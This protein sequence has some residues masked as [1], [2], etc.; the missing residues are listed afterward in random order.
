MLKHNLLLIFRGFK[1][2]KSSFVINLIGLSTG[3][4]CALLI[5]FWVNDELSVDRFFENGKQLFQVMQN[6]QGANG[7]ETID[8]TPGHLAKALSDEIPEVEY[9]VA[10]VPTSFN[11][12]KGIVS[13]SDKQIKSVGQYVSED[14]FNVFSYK[15]LYGNKN[16]MLSAQN[17][18]VISRELALKLYGSPGNAVGK[19]V[20]WKAQETDGKYTVSGVFDL[21]DERATNQFDVLLNYKLFEGANPWEG[22]GSSSPHTYVLLKKG[23]SSG[24]F[25][26]KIRDF[27]KS[28]DKN[29]NATLVAQRYSDRYL[30][31]RFENG[32]P[33]GGRI[34][35]VRL[36]S[37]IAIFI[38][39]I[40]CINFM[41]LSTARALGK[42][43]EVGIKKAIGAGR[44]NLIIQRLSESTVMA[45]AALALALFFVYL[46]KTPFNNLT[47]KHLGFS[48]D[49]QLV[50]I[51]LGITL[52]T[53][54]FAGSYPAFYLSRFAP[55]DV[56]KGKPDSPSGGIWARKGLV[57]FQF[58]ASVI[59]I[60]SV[61]VVFEQ[62]AF[63]QSKNLG[64]NRDHVVYF[65]VAKMSQATLSEIRNIPGVVNAA[66]GNMQA[67]SP[68]GGTSGINW[69]GKNPDDQT[70]FSVKWVGYNLIETLGMKMAAG[71]AFS[72]DFGS[73]DQV[74]FNETAIKTMG[75]TDPVG[76]QVT[77]EG[78]EK[79]IIGVIEDFNF[80]SLYEKVKPCVL[81][82]AP[83]QNAPKVSA[84]I[85]AE[86][87]KA[88]LESLGKT[89]QKHYPGQTFD[90]KYMDDD[91]QRLYVAEQRV[92]ALSKYFAGLAILISCLGLFGLAAFTAG[93]RTKEIGIRK[94]LG[95]TVTEIAQLLSGDFTRMVII[96]IVIALPVSYLIADRWLESFAY[97]IE[98]KWWYFATAGL[99][100]LLIAW[101]TVGIQTMK[102]ALVNP[103]ECLKEE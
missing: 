36:F 43:K 48:F 37:V 59:L 82:V 55:V 72:E 61:W 46:L 83:I 47:G 40:A 100:T 9:A 87:E 66:G 24:L 45:F 75:L 54:L 71:K 91:Y 103:V 15:I 94:V 60:V 33:A 28:K 13:T 50:L 85:K 32:K 1:R 78:E 98:L 17:S 11:I 56:L 92:S 41:N 18:V 44:R 7:I 97:R 79:Q 10:V 16:T 38:L 77:I 80:E 73:P 26:E 23:T 30:R 12:S 51:V 95:S 74:V 49:T 93:Q 68:L 42:I 27:I 102:S 31:V 62:M 34:E 57:V 69:E 58:V 21:P 70:F 88:T 8:A 65:D 5:F 89:Y 2:D 22:W 25:N 39:A 3:L 14:F 53:G 6:T 64:Y 76:Q 84:R 4:A 63:V 81:L 52:M 96:A 35:Y 29:L 20:D 101:F 67:G 86:A 90:Y 19:V 99:M